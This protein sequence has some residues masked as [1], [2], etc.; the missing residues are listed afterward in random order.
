MSATVVA[1]EVIASVEGRLVAVSYAVFLGRSARWVSCAGLAVLE[2]P[3]VI[4]FITHPPD[5][6]LIKQHPNSR[7]G[8]GEHTY[9]G[10]EEDDLHCACT[11]GCRWSRPEQRRRRS[12]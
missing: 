10:V 2:F 7:G 1:G 9:I 12:R 11:P 5:G 8:G 3:V 4:E 6:A